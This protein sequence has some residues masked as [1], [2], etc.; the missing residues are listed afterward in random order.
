[1]NPKEEKEG[2]LQVAALVK[3]LERTKL[4]LGKN[5]NEKEKVIHAYCKLRNSIINDT[6]CHELP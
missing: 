5:N 4:E 2:K 3:Q 6:S 1:M